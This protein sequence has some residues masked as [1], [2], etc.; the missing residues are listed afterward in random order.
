[1]AKQG[2]EKRFPARNSEA[3]KALATNA[4]RLRKLRGWSQDRL[5]SE[6]NIEQ[7]AVSLLENGRS[8]PTLIMIE[9]IAAAFGVPVT[10]LLDTPS[11]ARKTKR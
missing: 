1:M 5:A 11:R 6:L 8:N 7:N 3:V 2:F 9:A 10:E 4:R